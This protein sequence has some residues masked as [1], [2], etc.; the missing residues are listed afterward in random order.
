MKRGGAAAATWI[1]SA[2]A[3]RRRGRDVDNFRGG[4]STRVG[5]GARRRYIETQPGVAHDAADDEH[6]H[7]VFELEPLSPGGEAWTASSSRGG[8]DWRSGAR[9]KKARSAMLALEEGDLQF[10]YWR[11]FVLFLC[12]LD[13]DSDDYAP[14]KNMIHVLAQLVRRG[15]GLALVNGVLEADRMT[16]ALADRARRARRHLRRFL[17]DR[18]VEGFAD[19]V[20]APSLVAG[21]SLLLQAKGL[22]HFRPN[23]VA[24]GWPRGPRDADGFCRVVEDAT[25]VGKTVLCCGG[26]EDFPDESERVQG[27]VDVWMVF[28]LF[29]AAGLLLLLPF[30]LT[31]SHV[32]KGCQLRLVVV[33]PPGREPN[34]AWPSRCL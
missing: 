31:Q 3:D 2:E 34:F 13:P 11:P 17:R 20:V 27:H 26:K 9:F 4:R 33:S 6:G 5:T 1:I 18:N 29:P 24:L 28:D 7:V 19:V 32:W 12:K 8:A 21:Q 23:A 22:G 25:T 30:L 16:P 10:K 14:H 15:K